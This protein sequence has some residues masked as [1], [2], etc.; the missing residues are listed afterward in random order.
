MRPCCCGK[1]R[2]SA[3]STDPRLAGMM[4]LPV[5]GLPGDNKKKD[6]KGK[7][8]KKG[9]HGGGGGDVQ[10]NLIVDP[11]MFMGSGK[12]EEYESEGDHDFEGSQ[13]SSQRRGHG[14][15]Q[16][17]R[18]I[19]QGLAMESDWKVAR[20]F[21]RRMLFV[22]IACFIA[23]GAVFALV[24]FGKRCPPGGFNGW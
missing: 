4:V 21:V 5:Q 20:K 14:Q 19:F 6:K 22:D 10:V 2:K 12:N 9:K 17:R 24:L 3:D 23:W 15:A 13:V 8:G 16:Q 1:R 11:S 18:G 7:K